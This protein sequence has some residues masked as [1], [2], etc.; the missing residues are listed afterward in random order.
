MSVDVLCFWIIFWTVP[1]KCQL[2]NLGHLHK[3]KMVRKKKLLFAN[4]GQ[5]IQNADWHAIIK[6]DLKKNSSHFVI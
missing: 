6:K 5:K 2:K 4:P 3:M 1:Q